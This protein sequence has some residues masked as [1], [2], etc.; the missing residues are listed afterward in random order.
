MHGWKEETELASGTWTWM[1]AF[2]KKSLSLRY[3]LANVYA[4]CALSFITSPKWPVSCRD[5]C[6]PSLLSEAMGR[7]VNDS[8]YKVE[9]PAQG[10]SVIMNEF[11]S[12][13]HEYPPQERWERRLDNQKHTDPW[14][15]RPGP[16]QPQG[17][18]PDTVCQWWRWV[19]P[20]SQPSY[21]APHQSSLSPCSQSY[22]QPCDKSRKKDT[23]I[24]QGLINEEPPNQPFQS[25]SASSWLHSRDS[26]TW[27]GHSEHLPIR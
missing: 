12:K 13:L 14:Q 21:Q 10:K 6:W 22:K 5:P 11:T 7:D 15:S 27:W 17:V 23:R 25:A 16:W 3:D 4:I 20:Q 1:L 8:M 26:K 2:W 19:S 18:S 24:K 9:P